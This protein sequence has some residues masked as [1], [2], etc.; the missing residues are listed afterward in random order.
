MYAQTRAYYAAPVR[1]SHFKG[2]S[3]CAGQAMMMAQRSPEL[4]D[5]AAAGAPS[6]FYS[7]IP[8]GLRQAASLWVGNLSPVLEG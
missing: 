3:N 5:G 6:Q 8:T 2:C 1:H 4:P 7:A